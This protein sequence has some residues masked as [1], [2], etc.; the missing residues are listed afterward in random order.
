MLS[1][2][3]K[4]VCLPPGCSIK[5]CRLFHFTLRY[6]YQFVDPGA[7]QRPGSEFSLRWSDADSR[8]HKVNSWTLAQAAAG[9]R[10]AMGFRMINVFA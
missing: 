9:H 7:T 5:T 3:Y 4:L 8:A 10:G 2:Q 6:S 1:L